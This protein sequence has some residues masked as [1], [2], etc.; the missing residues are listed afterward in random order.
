MLILHQLAPYPWAVAGRAIGAITFLPVLQ[1]A[2]GV[3]SSAS[4]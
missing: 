2:Q 4:S 3:T 1:E